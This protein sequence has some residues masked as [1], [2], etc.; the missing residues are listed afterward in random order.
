MLNSESDHACSEYCTISCICHKQL[1]SLSALRNTGTTPFLRKLA[2]GILESDAVTKNPSRCHLH[3]IQQSPPITKCRC[4]GNCKNIH[5]QVYGCTRQ[6]IK[7]LSA[8][9]EILASFTT[10]S[11]VR[12][13]CCSILVS[14][15]RMGWSSIQACSAMAD[16]SVKPLMQ[17]SL[18]SFRRVPTRRL[19]SP[20]YTFPHARHRSINND[21]RRLPS[22]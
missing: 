20:M 14:S 5:L 12:L 17:A 13:A 11:I 18:C 1:L 7:D 21:A 22:T 2:S 4:T 19:V 16:L 9:F 15:Q 6:L 3:I 10:N 8:Q